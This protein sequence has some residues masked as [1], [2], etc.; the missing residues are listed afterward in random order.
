L[1]FQFFQHK[2]Y[3]MKSFKFFTTIFILVLCNNVFAQ[4]IGVGQTTPTMKLE[5]KASDSAVLL[6]NNETSSGTFI[7]SSL[8]FKTGPSFSGGIATV[9]S[10]GFYRMGL[11]TYGSSSPS[12]LLERISITDAGNVGIGTTTPG[13]TF[14]VLRGNAFDGTATFSGTTH[15]SH[16]NYSSSEDTYIRGGKDNSK[17]F[18]ADNPGGAVG[19]GTYT[20]TGYKLAVG[21]NIRSKEVVVET[22]WADFVFAKDYKLP[23]LVEVEKYIKA[24]NHLPEIPSAEEIQTNGLKVGEVQTKMMQKIE[25]LTL[26]IIEMKKEIE[27]LKII[28]DQ[29]NK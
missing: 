25:E 18:M 1:F 5:V 8:F 19:I 20:T 11:Y 7:K 24:N 3:T 15:T 10:S 27:A 2:I 6:L 14:S 4:N 12:G 28:V 23:S 21:G 17:V 9:G 26:Y 16:F 22:G 13:A 29:K